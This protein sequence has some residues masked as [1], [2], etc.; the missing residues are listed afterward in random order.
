MVHKKLHYKGYVTSNGD[1]LAHYFVN[2]D[3]KDDNI[4]FTNKSEHYVI[5]AVYS[6]E[7]FKDGKLRMGKRLEDEGMADDELVKEWMV[8]TAAQKA[9]DDDRIRE[10]S[11]ARESK[12]G[13][14]DMTLRELR[15]RCHSN[16]RFKKVV[17]AWLMRSGALW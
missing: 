14:D 6:I 11:F 17:F 13:F 3:D 12:N 2:L 16:T 15:E 1:K 5:G 8:E 7:H 10:R 4:C 9:S